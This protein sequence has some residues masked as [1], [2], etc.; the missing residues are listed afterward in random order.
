MC[1]VLDL[2]TVTRYTY[3]YKHNLHKMLAKKKENQVITFE[4][5]IT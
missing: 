3:E 2:N 4:V 1:P 5:L